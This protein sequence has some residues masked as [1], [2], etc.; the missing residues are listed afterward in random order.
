MAIFLLGFATACT[1]GILYPLDWIMGSG[2]ASRGPGVAELPQ[3]A[4]ELPQEFFYNIMFFSQEI[5][6]IYAVD[7][8]NKL[9]V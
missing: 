3:K 2:G 1:A 8:L 9:S 5:F 7:S 6:E 4:S